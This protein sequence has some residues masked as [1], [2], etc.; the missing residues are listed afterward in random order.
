MSVLGDVDDVNNEED[1]SLDG[2]IPETDVLSHSSTWWVGKS[3]MD[4]SDEGIM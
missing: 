4:N 1:V 3:W 2:M